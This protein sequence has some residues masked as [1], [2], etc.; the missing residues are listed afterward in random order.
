MAIHLNPTMHMLSSIAAPSSVADDT[1]SRLSDLP[2]SVS[3]PHGD[4]TQGSLGLYLILCGVVLILV[5][6][7]GTLLWRIHGNH[8]R[9][10]ADH[11]SSNQDREE[12]RQPRR[13]NIYYE[14]EP[15]DLQLPTVSY[16]PDGGAPAQ[17]NP[18]SGALMKLQLPATLRIRS[19]VRNKFKF[20][21]MK[22]GDAAQPW[23][24][25]SSSTAAGSTSPIAMQQAL[26]HLLGAPPVVP[27][28]VIS[29]CSPI[30]P[31]PASCAVPTVLP[32]SES[33]C[34]ASSDSLR[35]PGSGPAP[36]VNFNPPLKKK[37]FAS[38]RAA[39]DTAGSGKAKSKGVGAR[40]D[41]PIRRGKENAPPR[42][43]GFKGRVFDM[44]Q[45]A[46]K[47]CVRSSVCQLQRLTLRSHPCRRGSG[48]LGFRFP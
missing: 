16:I 3:S 33:A 9:S 36:L 28:I 38:R 17:G 10:P 42:G 30:I 22:L 23:R 1:D 37:S 11:S 18:K 31:S 40:A 46:A 35:V 25:R 45:G 13:N 41:S 21:T 19:P 7:A 4:S 32:A 20:F 15:P 47:P 34:L 14:Y 26:P 43:A 39:P 27:S 2:S 24:Q 12:Q 44:S 8:R 5:I 29:E 6:G 48:P